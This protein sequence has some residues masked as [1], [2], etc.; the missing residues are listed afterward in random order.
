MTVPVTLGETPAGQGGQGGSTIVDDGILSGL[1]VQPLDRA[2]RG[3]L[4]VPADVDGVV[5]TRLDR[6]GPMAATGLREGDVIVEVNRKPVT[7]VDAFRDAARS[8][9]DSALLL[10]YRDGATI[11]L[12]LSK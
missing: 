7:S 8:A 4:H 5:V 11:Y 2:L 9:T 6:R 1:A 10:V 12:S 3:Q